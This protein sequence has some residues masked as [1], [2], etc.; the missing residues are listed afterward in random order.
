MLLSS[1]L[2]K[3]S[4]L[5]RKAR[6]CCV[7]LRHN[8]LCDFLLCNVCVCMLAVCPGHLICTLVHQHDPPGHGAHCQRHERHHRR[9]GEDCGHSKPRLSVGVAPGRSI[10]QRRADPLAQT[11]LYTNICAAWS[12]KRRILHLSTSALLSLLHC[13]H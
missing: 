8:C 10:P 5:Q 1:S 13:P 7:M 3:L 6:P 9:R 4:K 2:H 11:S 12:V